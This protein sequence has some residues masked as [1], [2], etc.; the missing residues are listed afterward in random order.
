MLTPHW[1]NRHYLVNV[2]QQVTAIRQFQKCSPAMTLDTILY[3]Y[4]LLA[5]NVNMVNVSDQSSYQN[6]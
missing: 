6:I 4:K 5:I 1:A 2:G 3:V